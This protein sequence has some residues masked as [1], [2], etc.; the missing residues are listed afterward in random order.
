M[1]C[2]EDNYQNL[3][4]G[5]AGIHMLKEEVCKLHSFVIKIYLKEFFGS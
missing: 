4:L 5:I 3:V 1:N 2:S